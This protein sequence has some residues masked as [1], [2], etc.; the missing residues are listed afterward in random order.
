VKSK[1]FT[2]INGYA[3]AVNPSSKKLERIPDE[4][5]T[6]SCDNILDQFMAACK[7]EEGSGLDELDG[8]IANQTEFQVVVINDEYDGK[9]QFRIKAFKKA[10]V[11]VEVNEDLEK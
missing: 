3:C 11:L 4:G 9:D 2:N 8:V 7:M 5:K 10:Q 6:K 1:K